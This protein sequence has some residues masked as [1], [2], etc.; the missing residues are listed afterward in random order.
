MPCTIKSLSNAVG[1][2]VIGVDLKFA[3]STDIELIIKAL[4]E[5][6]VSDINPNIVQ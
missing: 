1:C 3:A 4:N 5:K 2:E 6:L